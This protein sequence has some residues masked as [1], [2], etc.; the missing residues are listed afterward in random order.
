MA[1]AFYGLMNNYLLV[2]IFISFHSS[3]WSGDTLSVCYPSG[4]ICAKIWMEKHLRY[5]IYDNGKSL[6]EPSD[7]DM[8][9]IHN[10]SF[11]FNNGIKSHTVK[12]ESH[13]ISS[14]V[15]EKRKTIHDDYNFMSLGFRQ[16]YKI[17]FR[18]Y[19]DG[20]A[21]R[22]ITLFKDSVIIQNEVAEFRF[23]GT[24]SAYFPGI[25]KRSDADIFHTSFEELYPL[26]EIDKIEIKEMDYSP[27]LI[28]PQS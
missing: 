14:P 16:P 5:R 11:S 23:P 22:F 12:K 24:P 13:L 8:V 19:D 20:V 21:Y 3:A 7:I 9:L 25:H 6:V 1:K 26:R 27:V 15:P 18:V 10:N 4:K 17:E 28:V 2:A